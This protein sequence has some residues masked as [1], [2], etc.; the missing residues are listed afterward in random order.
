MGTIANTLCNS[1][2]S[3]FTNIA[4]AEKTTGGRSAT[5]T[6]NAFG[7]YFGLKEFRP[8]LRNLDALFIIIV[9]GC[10]MGA[11]LVTCQ[12]AACYHF[13]HETSL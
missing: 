10:Q 12:T 8:F 1:A 4:M 13:F 3:D 9:K 2:F 5:V 11:A 6:I 7:C